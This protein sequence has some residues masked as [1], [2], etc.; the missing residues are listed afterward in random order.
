MENIREYLIGVVAA[1]VLCSVITVLV[2]NK[3]AVGT[4]IKFLSGL[5]MTLAVL[6]PWTNI[7]LDNLWG[8]TEDFTQAGQELVANGENMAEDAYRAGIKKQTEA[9]ILE[10]ARSLG[11]ELTVEVSLSPLETPIPIGVT[12]SGS[13]SP[14]AKER[15][16]QILEQ[17]LGIERKEQL[18]IG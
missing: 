14:Y 6:S 4:V 18:W 11:T 17:E 2:G 9:Y 15:L 12:L 10:K 13:I 8:W 3:G 7:S 5:L 16:S 1:A